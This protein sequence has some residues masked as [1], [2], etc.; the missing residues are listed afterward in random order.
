MKQ[1]YI[2][3]HPLPLYDPLPEW[4]PI[5]AQNQTRINHLFSFDSSMIGKRFLAIRVL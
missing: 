4:E 3:S 5:F 2:F 1:D